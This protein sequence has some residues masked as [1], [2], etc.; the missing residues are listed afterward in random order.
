[1]LC[2]A[3]APSSIQTTCG[4]ATELEQS[5]RSHRHAC[6]ASL[7][8]IRDDGVGS[9]WPS[10]RSSLSAS[11]VA[12]RTKGRAHRRPPH[13]STVRAPDEGGAVGPSSSANECSFARAAWLRKSLLCVVRS[14][15]AEPVIDHTDVVTVQLLMALRMSGA[16]SMP[17]LLGGVTDDPERRD[18][19]RNLTRSPQPVRG[20][21]GLP[22][23][24]SS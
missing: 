22:R 20:A 7:F 10:S 6:G 9:M 17:E 15:C 19:P 2:E 18:R 13:V 3:S 24:R 21:R 12:A 5:A 14:W 8:F 16:P 23:R 11:D 4:I 1:M